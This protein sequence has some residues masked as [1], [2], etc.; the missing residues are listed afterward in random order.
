MVKVPQYIPNVSARPIH[1]QNLAPVATPEAFGAGIGR[2]MQQLAQGVSNLG[3][4]FQAVQELEDQNRA[5]DADNGYAS[6]LRER[7]YGEG[8]FMTLEGRNAVD[9]R[10]AFEAEA[11]QKRM[12]FG[13]GLTGGAAK[14][15]Q[16]AS[17]ARIQTTLQQSIVHTANARKAWFK[18]ASAARA[19][20]F[21]N[22]AL[23]NF[24]NPA[25]VQ[26]NLAAGIM[27]LRERG[28]MEG[29]D[30]DTLKLRELEYASGVHKNI[31]LTMAQND[32]L[33]AD[34]YI[35]DN[36]AQMTAVDRVN[37]QK[38]LEGPILYAKA[39]RHLANITGAPVIEDYDRH[40]DDSGAVPTSVTQVT[41]GAKVAAGPVSFT[42]TVNGLMG[43]NENRDAGV[44]AD[45]IKRSAGI[46]IDPRTTAWCAAF[47]NGVLGAQGIEGT[48]KLNARSF[49]NFGMPTDAPKPG[50][51]VVLSRGDPNGWQGHVGFFQGY[52]ANG[53]IRVLGGNQ[54]NGVNV[55][56]YS[57]DKLLGFRTAGQVS[58]QT[59]SMPNY[60]PRGLEMI[61]Q[62]LAGIADPKEREATRKLLD[63][64]YTSQ[65]KM[66][67]AQREQVQGMVET[68]MATDPS[69]DPLKLP[70][71]YQSILGASGMTTLLNY[72]EK[73][74]AHGEPTTDEQAFSELQM[75]YADD[76]VAFADRN[77]WE[78]KDKLSNS[79]WR[80]VNDWKQT[81]RT[82]RRK[83]R[84][85]GVDLKAAY[86]QASTML[87][88][89]GITT[90]GKTGSDREEAAKRISRF[91]NMLSQ[92]LE[93]FKQQNGK[94]PNQME[95]QSMVNKL[96][97]PVVIRSERSMWNPL[98]TPWSSHSETEGFLFEAPFRPDDTSVDL[99]VKYEDIPADLRR[100]IEVDL[101]TELSRKPSEDEITRRYEEFLLS[102]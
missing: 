29:W 89:V 63:Q 55:Q 79:D 8:G 19:D 77:L 28:S 71:E 97:L 17:T 35:K 42:S 45:F 75:D 2:G 24:N 10:A 88:S 100:I 34:K 66:M 62:K 93:A 46:N 14:M 20:T 5:K 82:D 15:Y 78:Y 87:E 48:G 95:I 90:T 13:K 31:A 4:S 32:A 65:K 18:D 67:D 76:P 41:P 59:V 58:D 44:I 72:R 25:L 6:W 16:N 69:F 98:K 80:K 26:K 86:S 30:A 9:G 91:Q 81:A 38:Q 57:K 64:Y 101:E 61:S 99:R 102:R 83:A 53:N 73:V 12:E 74:L 54:S 94:S 33:A 21:A 96:L 22:D 43:L 36:A 56:S 23:A 92:E 49:L 70:I 40:S 1:Q 68:Q 11:E 47:V 39:E 50:D 51:I 37:L 3:A 84:E 60:G 7:M 52:D 85:D 27:E